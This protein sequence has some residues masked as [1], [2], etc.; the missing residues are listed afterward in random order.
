MRVSGT[1][2]RVII[3]QTK[4]PYSGPTIHGLARRERQR[5]AARKKQH[6][7]AERDAVVH[8]EPDEYRPRSAGAGVGAEQCAR[9]I[10]PHRAGRVAGPEVVL[11]ARGSCVERPGDETGDERDA[12]ERLRPGWQSWSGATGGSDYSHLVTVGTCAVRECPAER[13]AK[14]GGGPCDLGR[15]S[16]GRSPVA[17]VIAETKSG[18]SQGDVP[19]G[20][21][22]VSYRAGDRNRPWSSGCG[23]VDRS[24]QERFPHRVDRLD[25]LGRDGR[26][27]ES[28][29]EAMPIA[30]VVLLVASPRSV[31]GEVLRVP[32]R[33]ERQRLLTSSP[34]REATLPRIAGRRSNAWR[35]AHLRQCFAET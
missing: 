35:G 2:T 26:V 25:G 5:D 11:D 34:T 13:T 33:N 3:A 18:T 22:A 14:Q 24:L 17:A 23:A 31:G 10:A 12:Y 21:C 15:T 20:H 29:G 4:T 16:V 27:A 28:I 9:D 32:R 19:A 6:G 1:R 8:E 30:E 7:P